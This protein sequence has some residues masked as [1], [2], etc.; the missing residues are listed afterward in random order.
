M[1]GRVSTPYRRAR[2]P[3]IAIAAIVPRSARVIAIAIL[4]FDASPLGA[5]AAGDC[6]AR[7]QLSLSPVHLFHDYD[8]LCFMF[9]PWQLRTLRELARRETMAAVADAFSLTPSAVSQQIAALERQAGVPLIERDGR[10]VRLTRAGCV[11]AERADAI[12][13]ALQQAADD[14]LAVGQ[15]A[16]GVLRLASF[17]TVAAALC[18]QVINGL[19]DRFPRHVVTLADMEPASSL[20]ALSTGEIDLAIVDEPALPVAGQQTGLSHLEV[21]ADPLYCVM[22]HDH[23]AATQA[24]VDLRQ[25]AKQTWIMDAPTC[26]FYRLTVDLCQAA[27]FEPNVVANS[28]SVSVYSALIRAGAGIAILPGLAFAT[29][30]GDFA[31][32]LIVPSVVRRIYAAYRTGTDARPSMAV[33]LELLREAAETVATELGALSQLAGHS[34]QSRTP[35]AARGHESAV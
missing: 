15:D 35:R 31:F 32:R 9:D 7:I 28:E 14:A 21:Y 34:S 26:P 2:T 33:A 11:L 18:P 17:P 27:G 12:L 13:T 16:A 19:A 24:E 30:G 1:V 29:M 20:R 22:R 5:Q 8:K 25:M 23:A 6:K 3:N 4:L 10:R